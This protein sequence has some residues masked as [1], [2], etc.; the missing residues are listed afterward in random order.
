MG[1]YV[2]QG[3]EKTEAAS[4]L[5]LRQARE[6]GQ[7]AKSA[8]VV[9]LCGLGLVLSALILFIPLMVEKTSNF[10]NDL[11]LQSF[12]ENSIILVLRAAREGF[13]LWF[14]MSIPILLAAGLGA[15]IGSLGQFGFLFTSHPLKPDPQRINPLKGLKKIV[16]KDRFFEL[17]KQLLK[18]MAISWVIFGALK[19][20]I[21][22]LSILF[23]ITIN[24]AIIVM[25]DVVYSVLSRVLLCFLL[26]A[27]ADWFWQRRSFSKSMRMSKYEVKKEYKQ[28]E[29][30]P[31][32]KQE[33][34]RIHQEIIESGGLN[35]I[36]DASVVITN[37]SHLAV[38]LRYKDE[39]DPVP[40]VVAKGS[41]ND[42][43]LLI[44]KANRISV[45]VIRNVPLARDLVWLDINEEIP[46]HLYEGVAE[47][48]TFIVELNKKHEAGEHES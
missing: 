29:G 48:L 39:I 46:E 37:P 19:E 34:R 23:R 3:E 35:A 7:V 33:R 38:A 28:Q 14:F 20:S 25:G 26:I 21:Y 16:S 36:E 40:V 47:V 43:K 17:I 12:Q 9:A 11:F 31:H 18:F 32:V 15:I 6:K 45:P 22:A 2:A 13:D 8:D 42:A 27:L 5:K 41:G 24:S 30:D 4:E 44:A 1:G 10:I